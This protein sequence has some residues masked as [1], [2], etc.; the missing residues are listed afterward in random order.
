[1]TLKYCKA[2]LKHLIAL[3][4]APLVG[5]LLVSSMPAF[6]QAQ[7]DDEP[8]INAA[9][10][11]D[12]VMDLLPEI[13]AEVDRSLDDYISGNDHSADT[14]RLTLQIG[15]GGH[16][17]S[18]ADWQKYHSAQYRKQAPETNAAA[19]LLTLTWGPI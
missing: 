6:A 18:S 16:V 1:M 13:P 2:M 15:P 7:D 10:A 12:A 17:I 9:T 4:G 11:Q 5:A 19:Q 8:G 14:R 3:A